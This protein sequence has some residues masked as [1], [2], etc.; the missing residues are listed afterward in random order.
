MMTIARRVPAA[1]TVAFLAVVLAGC[2]VATTAGKT[3]ASPTTTTSSNATSAA[4][5]AVVATT[6]PTLSPTIPPATTTMISTPGT[7]VTRID[8]PAN[9]AGT[10]VAG[11]QLRLLATGYDASIDP[12]AGTTSY[13]F[14]LHNPSAGDDAIEVPYHVTAY[15]ATGHVLA[16]DQNTIVLIQPGQ[17]LGV[18]GVLTMTSGVKIARMTYQINKGQAQPGSASPGFAVSD[19]AY[20]PGIPG[21]VTGIV[22]NHAKQAVA[23][24]LVTA[25]GFNTQGAIIGGAFTFLDQPIAV[26]GTQPVSIPLDTA[27]RPATVKMFATLSAISVIGQ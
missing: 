6:A 24:V 5:V 14:L 27:T 9:A 22:T 11:G 3:H 26:G 19:V 1:L 4:T 20:Q 18:A 15:D 17:T 8:S 7:A 21:Q 23:S 12:V 16:T 10:S 13:A 25:I 2:G